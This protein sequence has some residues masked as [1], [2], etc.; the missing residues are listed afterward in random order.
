ML[1]ILII[2]PH[3]APTNAPDMQRIRLLLPHF[4]KH[5]VKAKV[6]A[7]SPE[8]VDFPQDKW[9]ESEIPSSSE[10]FRVKALGF[11]W[12]KIPGL[13]SVSTR[14]FASL[15]RQG[16]QL[17]EKEGFDLVYFSTTQFGV[18]LLGP[19]WKSKFGVPF[20][21]DFQDPWVNDYYRV[22]PDIHPPGGRIKFAAANWFNRQA[23][24]RVIRECLGITSVSPAYPQSIQARY[25][26]THIN[27]WP[28][29]SGRSLTGIPAFVAPFPAELSE[30]STRVPASSQT[31]FNPNDGNQHWLYAGRC[32]DYM[33]TS[34]SA[35]FLAF[36]QLRK[37]KPTIFENLSIHFVGTQYCVDSKTPSPIQ[38]LAEK[39]D[40]IDLVTEHPERIP[41]SET[42]QCLDDA[43]LLIV[44][45][46]DDPGY[47]A[48]KIF[49]YILSDTPTLGVFH[50]D[51]SVI[52]ISKEAG[53]S[54]TI[55]FSSNCATAKIADRILLHFDGTAAS[56]DRPINRQVLRQ[57]SANHQA[58]QLADFFHDCLSGQFSERSGIALTS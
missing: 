26:D 54:L 52:K 11:P 50:E 10:V 15:R 57:Y 55:P 24:P 5:D 47:S 44:P 49:P 23:E 33:Q 48:S 51:S 25:P 34:L 46:S 18:H 8:C 1:N 30:D 7:V 27:S 17:L 42:M 2:S 56:I 53:G 45:G 19:Y 58:G 20:V 6:L 3:F 40:L 12:R 14:S 31:I 36:Q 37:E 13:G 21:M 16:N 35:L 22:N 4:E 32:G 41:Y 9:L 28:C 39:Y 38:K 29:D 43:N